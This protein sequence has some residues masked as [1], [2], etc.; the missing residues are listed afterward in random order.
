MTVLFCKNLTR[1]YNFLTT[2]SFVYETH[3]NHQ[4]VLP[5]YVQK[6]YFA[7]IRAIRF[8]EKS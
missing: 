4:D 1:I 3:N 6:R 7:K 2:V 8:N 5:K